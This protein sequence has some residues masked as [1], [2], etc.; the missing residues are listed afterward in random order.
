MKEVVDFVYNNYPE[1]HSKITKEQVENLLKIYDRQVIVVKEKGIFTKEKIKGV[2]FYLTLSDKTLREVKS[3]ILDTGNPN[4]A[5][6]LLGDIGRNI[7]FV[8]IV[9]KEGI[10]TIL[11]GMKEVI[12]R[13]KAKTV[14]W[15]SEDRSR[16]HCY[17]LGGNNGS[18]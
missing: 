1:I 6:Y 7:H 2:G 11:K 16:F 5:V 3:G 8:F 17:N 18:Y 13:E 14:S 12:K 10:K 15:Y 9:I 4:N